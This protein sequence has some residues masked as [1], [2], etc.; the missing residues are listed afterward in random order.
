MKHI[1]EEIKVF[2]S[3]ETKRPNWEVVDRFWAELKIELEIGRNA[4]IK[5]YMNVPKHRKMNTNP[6]L[7]T[8]ESEIGILKNKLN[9]K[10]EENLAIQKSLEALYKKHGGSKYKLPSDISDPFFLGF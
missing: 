9:E 6:T 4:D 5:G 2:F 1:I 10:N 8:L 7:D 3:L